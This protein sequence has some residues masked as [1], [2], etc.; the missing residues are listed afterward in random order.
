MLLSHIA[1]ILGKN[2]TAECA[3]GTRVPGCQYLAEFR[4]AS[5]ELLK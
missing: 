4:P 1:A 3:E 5:L 2:P